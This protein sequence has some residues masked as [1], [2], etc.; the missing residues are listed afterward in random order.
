EPRRRRRRLDEIDHAPDRAQSLVVAND[1]GVG[2]ARRDEDQRLAG[3][4]GGP[5]G[6][7]DDHRVT[8]LVHQRC[9]A[10]LPTEL[11]TLPMPCPMAWPVPATPPTMPPAPAAMPPRILA[12]AGFLS[13]VCEST[14]VPQ[15]EPQSIALLL[16]PPSVLPQK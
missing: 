8:L 4:L 13:P 14:H 1:A 10:K 15:P 7:S 6:R 3:S 5:R 12:C 11:A 9:F 16:L 2:A